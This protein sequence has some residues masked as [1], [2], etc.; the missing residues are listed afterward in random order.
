MPTTEYMEHSWAWHW[1]VLGAGSQGSG[2][3]YVSLQATPQGSCSA[4]QLGMHLP[5]PAAF[6]NN[7]WEENTA[8]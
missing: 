8:F 2:C 4:S 5:D 3:T 6:F 1:W 7:E